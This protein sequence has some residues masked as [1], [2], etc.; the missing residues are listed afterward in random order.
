MNIKNIGICIISMIAFTSS[1]KKDDKVISPP[2]VPE[3]KSNLHVKLDSKKIITFQ[4]IVSSGTPN[5]LKENEIETYFGDRVSF[6]IPQELIVKNDS[7]TIVKLHGVTEKFKS[8]WDKDKLY[9][10]TGSSDNWDLLGEKSGA[11]GF[12]MNSGFYKKKSSPVSS[13]SLVV[14][15]QYNLKSYEG[16]TNKDESKSTL[17]WLNVESFYK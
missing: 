8:K 13:G 6:F 15:Q 1:C 2:V 14:G 9:F 16:L 3:N 7:V 11:A 4:K 10:Q 12:L 17:I 5:T